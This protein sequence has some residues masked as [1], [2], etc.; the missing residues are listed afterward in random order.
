MNEEG[1][2]AG[3]WT[4]DPRSRSLG[5]ESMHV[6]RGCQGNISGSVPGNISW[7]LGRVILVVGCIG[8]GESW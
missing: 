2:L 1:N 3:V 5:R 7:M 8:D 4:P 6:T